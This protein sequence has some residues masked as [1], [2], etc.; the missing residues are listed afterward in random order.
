[1]QNPKE[2]PSRKIE[3]ELNQKTDDK[4]GDEGDESDE[5]DDEDDL[6]LYN[7]ALALAAGELDDNLLARIKSGF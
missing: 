5:S 7:I 3:G 6:Y 4:S 1:M 2:S